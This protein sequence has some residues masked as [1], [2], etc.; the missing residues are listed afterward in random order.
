MAKICIFAK[1]QKYLND[2]LVL[3]IELRFWNVGL[4][5]LDVIEITKQVHQ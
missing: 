2:S 5:A 3:V 4:K 1:L